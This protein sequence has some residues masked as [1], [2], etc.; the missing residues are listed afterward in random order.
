[1]YSPPIPAREK[2]RAPS[3][4]K[5]TKYERRNSVS[6]VRSSVTGDVRH[7]SPT[8]PYKV[9]APLVGMRASS[10]SLALGSNQPAGRPTDR[11]TG[12]LVGWFVGP[13]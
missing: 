13:V 2:Y 5:L 3:Q 10:E 8:V 6:S 11:P 1:M 9:S 12:W 7:G 4:P